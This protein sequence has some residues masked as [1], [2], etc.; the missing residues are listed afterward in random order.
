MKPNKSRF[1]WK[2]RGKSFR[3]A[4][5]GICTLFREEHNAR[6]HLA[7]TCVV[8]VCGFLFRISL[9]EWAVTMVCIGSV[10]M[11]E[12]FNSA[13]E[14]LADRVDMEKNPLIGKAK[15]LASGAVLLMACGSAVAGLI[16]FVPKILDCILK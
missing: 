11:A 12:G 10:L 15:D 1:S 5:T 9:S 4:W 7:I 3:Y 8:I 16:I 2:A 14:A 6:I 13:I